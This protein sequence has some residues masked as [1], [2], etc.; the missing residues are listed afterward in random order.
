M[1]TTLPKVSEI[2]RKW[3]ELDA[4]RFTLGRLS[5]RAATLLR[6]KHKPSFTPHMDLGDFV[7]V[8]N[9]RKVK[10]TGRKILQKER[11]TF[12]GYPGGIRRTLL[13]DELV[14]HPERV[15]WEAVRNM[16]PT[17]RLRRSELRRLKILPDATHTYKIDKRIES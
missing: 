8:T 14:K 17:N 3:Y 1:T 10:L 16:L 4:S 12:S 9:A 15:I 7:V 11:I 6:G 2:K 13:R 5:T